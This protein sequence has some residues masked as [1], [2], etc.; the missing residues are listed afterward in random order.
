MAMDITP[1]ALLGQAQRA[2]R[3]WPFIDDIEA[4]H[5]LPRG[6]LYA[7]GSRETGLLNVPG[8]QG[9]GHGIWQRDDRTWSIPDGFDSEPY[10][11]GVAAASLLSTLINGS[12]SI[13]AA[14]NRYN[15]GSPLASSTTGGNYGP[16]VSA[17]LGYLRTHLA[18]VF[19]GD[20]ALGNSDADVS[21]WQGQLA[22]RG[23]KIT[24]DG[25]YGVQTQAVTRAF[26]R[27][28]KL[29]ADGIVGTVTWAAG[30][31]VPVTFS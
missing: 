30:W 23:W 24:V 13:M 12:E 28:K 17:R 20:L 25:L 19:A 11:Q 21:L 18:P 10:L 1:G 8:D 26:Q 29:T 4:D 27:D 2:R 7:V 22:W 3:S 5:R 31:S 15:S 6:L 14:L 16:D 9:H